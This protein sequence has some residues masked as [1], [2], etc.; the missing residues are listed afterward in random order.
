MNKV[1]TIK[2][3]ETEIKASHLNPGDIAITSGGLFVFKAL[4]NTF[5]LHNGNVCSPD[6]FVTKLPKGTKVQLEVE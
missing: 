3:V 5:Y 2:T 4:H 6:I 1:T